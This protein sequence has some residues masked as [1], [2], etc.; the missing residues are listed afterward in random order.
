MRRVLWLL[1]D[2]EGELDEEHWAQH[3][4]DC[5]GKQQS[6][7][8]IQRR[9]VR[10]NPLLQL[11][12][13]G[14]DEPLQGQLRMTNNGH[15]VQIDLPPTMNISRG[16]PGVYTAVQMH[17]HWGGLDLES[18]GSEHTIDGMRYFAELHIVHYN[19][20][21]YSSFEEAK[22]KPQGLAVLAF[23]YTSTSPLTADTISA[24]FG[25]HSTSLSSLDIQAMLPENLSHFYRYQG[26]LTTPPCSES[27]I[28]T[29]FHSPIVL[30]HTQVQLLE[31]TLLDWHNRSLRNDYRHAQPLWGRVVEASFRA[32]QGQGR[33]FTLR[34]DQIQMQLQDMKRELLNGLSHT[35]K[36]HRLSP[37]HLVRMESP[38]ELGGPNH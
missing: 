11:E 36:K 35:G 10:Y 4:P 23:L 6:P 15:S 30:S 14:Y 19:S 24:S 1:S 18:S 34:L 28:W 26:S 25:G 9:K 8:D 33:E 2:R 5:A 27:V 20:A 31:N 22:D 12:L 13:G 37:A 3:F 21:N 32:Q 7:I 17:L 29:I 38:A 16:L